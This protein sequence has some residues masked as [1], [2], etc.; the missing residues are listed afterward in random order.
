MGTPEDFVRASA[1]LVRG[2]APSPALGGHRGEQLV[3]DGAA[4]SPARCSSAALSSDA[5]PR[6]APAPGWTAR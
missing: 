2:I 6:S 5:A 1:D 4:V 3:H